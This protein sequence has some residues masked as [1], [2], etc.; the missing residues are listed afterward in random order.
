MLSNDFFHRLTILEASNG[1]QE[2]AIEILLSMNDPNYK[3]EMNAVTA[4]PPRTMVRHGWQSQIHLSEASP[5]Y[6]PKKNWTS[7]SPGG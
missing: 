1:N 7:N 3:P 4:P 5:R 2:A 6:R